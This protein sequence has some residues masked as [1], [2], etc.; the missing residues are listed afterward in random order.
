MH[1]QLAAIVADFENARARMRRI[2]TATPEERWATRSDPGRWSVAECVAHLN[3]TSRPYIPLLRA[4][5]NDHPASTTVAASHRYRRDGAGWLIGTLSGPLLGIGRFRLGR[6]KTKPEFVPSATLER[7]R[8][9]AEFE[10]LQDEQI[11]LTQDASGRPLEQIRIASPFDARVKY[12]A[13]SCLWLLPRHQHRHLEQAEAVWS[14][15]T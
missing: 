13:Y 3:L 8:V 12:N 2:A 10:A 1:P 6:V 14:R 15:P 11:A 9:V 4:A 5:F 7:T